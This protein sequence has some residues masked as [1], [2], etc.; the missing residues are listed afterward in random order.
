[1]LADD[2]GRLLRF[3]SWRRRSHDGEEPRGKRISNIFSFRGHR[4]L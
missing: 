1:M 2:F 3:S 4:T